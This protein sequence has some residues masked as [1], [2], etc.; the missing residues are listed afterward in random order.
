MKRHKQHTLIL[1][2]I[3]L[4]ILALS[5]GPVFASTFL[6]NSARGLTQENTTVSLET[7]PVSVSDCGVAE[8]FVDVN[9]V[10]DLYGVD[11]RLSFDPAVIEVVDMTAGGN[12]NIL[13]VI[14]S[15][16]FTTPF[17]A[18]FMVRNIVDNFRGTI[19]YASASTNPT[20]P[21]QGSGHVA[22][23]QIRAKSDGDPNFQFTY[24]KLSDP[25]G[26]EI[27]ATGV[28]TPGSTASTSVVPDLDIIRLDAGTVQLQWP[29]VNASTVNQYHIYR[30]TTP[31]FYADGSGTQV[32]TT[33]TNPGTGTLTFNDAVLGN[34]VDNYFYAVRAECTTPSGALSAPSDQVGKFEYELFE[35][36]GTDFAWVGLVLDVSP[37]LSDTSILANHIQNNSNGSVTVKTISRWNANSQNFT[38]Y[39]P[40]FPFSTF[41]TNLKNAYRVE[42]DI[43]ATSAGTVIWAQVGKLP[44]ITEDTYSLYET[45]GTDYTW[46]LQP[47]DLTN[48]N[49][50]Q[51][52]SNHIINNSSGP[53]GVLTIGR[54]NGSSQNL[55]SYNPQFGSIGNYTTRFGYPYRI[56]VNVNI[57]NMV[58]WP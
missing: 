25:N 56:E 31:Y 13:P 45:T 23:F 6:K 50:A 32:V 4:T 53:V 38:S 39:N 33:V 42:V 2:L 24:I 41:T 14:D 9:D 7:L 3:G 20:L 17:T 34:V 27:P 44:V 51:A 36:T 40:L 11:F 1:G 35:T 37:A 43:P 5:T 28:I 52:L 10:T 12:V 16:G 15:T 55:T 49:S 29:A 8:L 57:G 47:L 58:T 48:V 21:A 46:V 30:S 26:V 18:N 54:W 19:W 22:R